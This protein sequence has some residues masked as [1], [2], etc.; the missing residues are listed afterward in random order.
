MFFEAR[1]DSTC[2]LQIN[3]AERWRASRDASSIVCICRIHGALS[4]PSRR[5]NRGR[6]GSGVRQASNERKTLPRELFIRFPVE[7][8]WSADQQSVKPARCAVGDRSGIETAIDRKELLYVLFSRFYYTPIARPA[9]SPPNFPSLRRERAVRFNVGPR[10]RFIDVR[11]RVGVAA[12]DRA[13]TR[14]SFWKVI[15]RT[16]TGTGGGVG[17][18][19]EKIKARDE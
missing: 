14:Y 8:R 3:G 19:P 15:T 1:P 17:R 7:F 6:V 2:R 16:R 12:A 5:Y 13:G 9:T 10:A 4:A 18:S 11:V